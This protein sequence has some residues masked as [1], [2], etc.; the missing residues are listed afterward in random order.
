MVSPSPPTTELLCL[1]ASPGPYCTA[2]LLR[3]DSVWLNC[4]NHLCYQKSL[5]YLEVHVYCILPPQSVAGY[6]SYDENIDTFKV[7]FNVASKIK[8]H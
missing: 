1:G 6:Q 7:G 4:P 2:L 8:F 3:D 5:L